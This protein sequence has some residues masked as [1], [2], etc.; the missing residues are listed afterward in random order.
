MNTLVYSSI[1]F[2]DNQM[3][4]TVKVFVLVLLKFVAMYLKNCYISYTIFEILISLW[5]RLCPWDPR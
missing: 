4:G 2:C 3:N 1:L 5:C